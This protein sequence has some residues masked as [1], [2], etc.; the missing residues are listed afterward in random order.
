VVRLV[1]EEEE[2]EEA[3]ASTLFGDDLESI[4]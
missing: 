4:S 1:E 3:F 2:E